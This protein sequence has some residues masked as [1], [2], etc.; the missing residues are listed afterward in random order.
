MLRGHPTHE[1]RRMR[2]RVR[3]PVRAE[4]PATSLGV[5]IQTE[6]YSVVSAGRRRRRDWRPNTTNFV[7]CRSAPSLAAPVANQPLAVFAGCAPYAISDRP[8]Q[9]RDRVVEPR[10]SLVCWRCRGDGLRRAVAR[11]TVCFQTAQSLSKQRHR[12]CEWSSISASDLMAAGAARQPTI[13]SSDIDA[14]AVMIGVPDVLLA[15]SASDWTAALEK[16]EAKIRTDHGTATTILFTGIP[17]L[18]DFRP[19]PQL[20]RDIIRRQTQ[21]LNR[22]TQ[23][24]AERLPQRMLPRIPTAARRGDIDRRNILLENAALGLSRAHRPST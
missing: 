14:I 21:L 20:A 13:T 23:S 5:K 17:P 7:E 2:R 22:T 9:E 16:I 1:V 24:V 10:P 15:T 4:S 3:L 19:I 8:P 18:A 12:V 11:K 6:T